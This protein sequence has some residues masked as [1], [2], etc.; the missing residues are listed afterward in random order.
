[1]ELFFFTQRDG[2]RMELFCGIIIS[3]IFGTKCVIVVFWPFK[4]IQTKNKTEGVWKKMFF[5]P[6][7]GHEKVMPNSYHGKVM[8][9]VWNF[10]SKICV[11][12]AL[13]N[14]L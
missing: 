8:E 1:M 10:F 13:V 3:S 2:K 6:K 14:A 12:P 5:F 4:L 11:N 7:K 9:K